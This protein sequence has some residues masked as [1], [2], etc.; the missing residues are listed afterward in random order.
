LCYFLFRTLWSAYPVEARCKF[1][2]SDY[3]DEL[4]SVIS[5][6]DALN[7]EGLPLR[8]PFIFYKPISRVLSSLRIAYHLSRT[9]IAIGLK[10]PTLQDQASNLQSLV[11]LV[12]QHIR[13]TKLQ[14]SP[15]V[16]VSS[17]L[18][19]SPSPVGN[20]DIGSLFSVALSVTCLH[21]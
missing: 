2:S 17:Y 12:F 1:T 9:N 7:D 15:I 19:F 21:F 4:V 14:S 11:Y 5:A 8:K 18:T 20:P 16:L 13:F 3:S 6:F 10:Q